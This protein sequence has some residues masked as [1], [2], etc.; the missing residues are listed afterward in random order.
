MIFFFKSNGSF[1][2]GTYGVA[3]EW[4]VASNAMYHQHAVFSPNPTMTLPVKTFEHN[5][6]QAPPVAREG[7]T[8]SANY[9]R[10]H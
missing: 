8:V 2:S 6:A 10:R 7:I 5:N 4:W 1:M 9:L 3:D